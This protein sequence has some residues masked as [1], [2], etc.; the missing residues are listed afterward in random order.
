MMPL[1]LLLLAL[2][3]QELVQRV[4]NL[5][6]SSTSV[7]EYQMEILR[8]RFHRTLRFR[9]WDDR[10]GDRSLVLILEPPKDRGTVFLKIQTDLWMYLPRVRR[11]VRIPPSMMMNAW[12]GSDF[13][14]DDVARSSSLSRDYLPQLLDQRG[15]TVWLELT[16]KPEAPVVWDRIVLKMLLP[17][18]P[19]EEHYYNARGE[20]VRV[21]TFSE[22]KTLHG[23]RLPTVLEAV[24]LNRPGHRTVLRLLDVQFDVPMKDSWFQVTRLE[25]IS[26]RGGP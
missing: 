11:T 8:P 13:T 24:P 1:L 22:V 2:S 7:G 25:E 4:E 5:L 19:L 6:R 18:L 26:T 17:N 20:E 16:P 23:R 10:A 21:I 3:P 12:M 9:F 15:D 14:N